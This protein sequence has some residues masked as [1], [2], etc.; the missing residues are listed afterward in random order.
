[1]K[2]LRALPQMF[3]TLSLKFRTLFRT[4]IKCTVLQHADIFEIRNLH[5]G[6]LGRFRTFYSASQARVLAGARYIYSAHARAHARVWGYAK[7]PKTS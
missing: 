4:C 7:R 1:M 2:I 3:R 5:L 6:R